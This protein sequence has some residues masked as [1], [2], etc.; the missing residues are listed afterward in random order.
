MSDAQIKAQMDLWVQSGTLPNSIMSVDMD[1]RVTSVGKNLFDKSS[2]NNLENS[3]I[4]SGGD[5]ISSTGAIV[6]HKI[7][8][9][10]A[11]NITISNADGRYQ[12]LDINNNVLQL[13]V[14]GGTVSLTMPSG[15][16][17]IRY[18]FTKATYIDI[19]QLELGTVATTYEPY[20]S[21]SMYLD[22]GEVGYS[23]PN[24]TKDTIEFR[25]GQAYHVQRV[26]K[27]TLTQDDVLSRFTSYTNADIILIAKKTDS[28]GYN[29][30]LQNWY[31]IP[32]YINKDQM[33]D[34]LDTVGKLSSTFNA[35]QLA[36]GVAKGTYATIQE[37][38]TALEGTD[39]YYQLDTPIET[40]ISVIGNAMAYPNGTF[41]IE[42]VVRRS[43]VYN[44]GITVDKAISELD[45]IYKL[46]DDGSSTKLAVSGATVAGDG[47]SFTHT[48]LSN[49]DFVWFDY[50]Y[51]GT[52]V[53]GLSTVYYYDDKMIVVD[54]V[55]DTVYRI[56]F[57]IANG[58]ITVD[59]ETI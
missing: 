54:S 21:S 2:Q 4:N 50:Y 55:T 25:N 53:K 22:S 3:S 27:Y 19:T 51:Q 18:A 38:K 43:G 36:L 10:E 6:T 56:I 58:V 16:Y 20:R 13:A 29:N 47:L 49:G 1:K 7:R 28:V 41:L 15:A 26:K 8:V 59:K 24:S 34:S 35:T 57:T 31:L 32:P 23:L 12:I 52:N 33:L 46:N 14:I 39:I 9:K 5:I 30:T 17:Y 37:A 44:G 48:S 40:P 45:N 42:D 11:Q